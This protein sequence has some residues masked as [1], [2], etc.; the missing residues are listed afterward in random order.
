MKNNKLYIPK[1]A[2][3]NREDFD[4]WYEDGMLALS[5]KGTWKEEKDKVAIMGRTGGEIASINADHFTLAYYVRVEHYTYTLHTHRIFQRY[6]VEG[7]LWDI[8]GSLTKT[9]F[10]FTYDG[11][12]QKDVRVKLVN[13]RDHGECYEVCAKDVRKLRIAAICVIAIAIKEEFK[14]KS[15]GTYKP[16]P[17]MTDKLKRMVFS[18]K[19]KTY[20]ELLEEEA[21]L[22]G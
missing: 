5:V 3:S 13:F 20:E 9:P 14:G 15:E 8:C 11:L 21:L 18:N 19:G 2:F 1:D 10:N 22:Q 7:M 4:V 6:S 17:T 16:N 12:T